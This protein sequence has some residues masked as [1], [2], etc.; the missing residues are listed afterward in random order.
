MRGGMGNMQGMMKK[1]Q[2]MQK[3]MQEAQEA[4]NATEFVGTANGDLV[5]VTF[6][7][8]KKMT[9]INIDPEVI[10]PEDSEILGDLILLA[11]NDAL[12]KIDAQTEASMGKYTKGLGIPGL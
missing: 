9:A 5:T 11:T 8:D 4:L 2:K 1:M 10:D 7:G 6:T 3:E 12:A